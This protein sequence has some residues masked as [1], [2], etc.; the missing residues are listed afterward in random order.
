MLEYLKPE[1]SIASPVSFSGKRLPT[2][3][4][5]FA[6]YSS[7]FP[8]FWRMML[9]EP[10]CI[11]PACHNS[12][13]Y[14]TGIGLQQHHYTIALCKCAIES[15]ESFISL[16]FKVWISHLH[17]SPYVNRDYMHRTQLSAQH[18]KVKFLCTFVMYSS[19]RKIV[20]KI[21]SSHR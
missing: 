4:N 2:F 8:W 13:P 14:K 21:M 17:K 16:L 1:T 18:T 12:N 7:G 15:K 9:D 20:D 11:F 19:S 5:P 3:R 6:V 10:N